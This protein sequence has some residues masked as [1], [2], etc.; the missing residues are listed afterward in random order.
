MGP[1]SVATWRFAWNFSL[2][3]SPEMGEIEGLFNHEFPLRRPY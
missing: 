1:A 2:F 3:D